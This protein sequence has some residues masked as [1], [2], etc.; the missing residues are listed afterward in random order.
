MIKLCVIASIIKIRKYYKVLR[1]GGQKIRR[2]NLL[3]YFIGQ[4]YLKDKRKTKNEIVY[5][6]FRRKV[7]VKKK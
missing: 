3:K 1:E 2:E 7:K 6:E 5:N 4:R